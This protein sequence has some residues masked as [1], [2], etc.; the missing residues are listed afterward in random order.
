MSY[1]STLSSW[2]KLQTHKYELQS[3]VTKDLFSFDQERFQRFSFVCHDV[4][5]DYSKNKITQETMALFEC[6]AQELS[7][8]KKI[9]DLFKGATVNFTEKRPALHMALRSP[10]A[11]KKMVDGENITALI[12]QTKEK[13]AAIS[14]AIQAGEYLGATAKPINTIINLGIGGSDL[15]PKMVLSAL[16]PYAKEGLNYAFVSN[17]DGQAL[18]NALAQADPERTLFIISSKSFTTQ[19]TLENAKSARLWL[20][21]ALNRDDL[22]QHFIAVTSHVDKACAFGIDEQS[23]LPMWDWVGGRFSLWSA[24]GLI[25]AIVLGFDHF[26]ALLEGAHAMDEHFEKTPMRE[27]VPVLSAFINVWNQHFFGATSHAI[28]PYSESLHQFTEHLQQMSMESLG[29]SVN[30][31]GASVDQYRTGPVIW[32][33]AGTNGQHSF[34]QWLHQGRGRF[35]CD[36]ILSKTTSSCFDHHAVLLSH[37]LAQSQALMLGRSQAQASAALEQKGL[38][39]KEAELLAPHLAMPGDRA[40][41]SIILPELSPFYLGFLIA[42]YEHTVFVQSV[43]WDINAFDQWGVELGKQLASTLLPALKQNKTVDADAS[44]LGLIDFL[45]Q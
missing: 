14:R 43:I 40:S 27:N 20:K 17:V 34:H 21:Q 9:K 4:L 33:G 30:R 37:G 31:E 18:E 2:K 8:D 7:L 35:H 19:E 38:S 22:N 28:L 13:M 36:F 32:G 42:W 39:A 6:L 10:Q 12:K 16:K 15:G 3:I 45:N 11:K 41:T 25:I 23:I 44:T 5:V 26:S 29:K 24:I 1:L